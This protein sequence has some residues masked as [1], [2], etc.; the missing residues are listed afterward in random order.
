MSQPRDPLAERMTAVARELQSEVAPETLLDIAARL[1]VENVHGC[2]AAGISLV[3]RARV[4]E[5]PAYTDRAAHVSDQLQLE[6]DEGPGLDAIW[7]RQVVHSPDLAAE[8]RWPSWGPRT[9]AETGVRSLLSLRLFT[10]DDLVG[11]LN[12]YSFQA[13]AFDEAAVEDGLALAGHIAVAVTS[14][15]RIAQLNEALDS[16]TSIAAA[17][18]ILM[19]RFDLSYDRAFAVLGRISAQGNVKIRDLA[20]ELVATGSL[21]HEQETA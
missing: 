5:T 11:A 17:V 2:E 7:E 20:M 1:A 12:L 9:V 3:R 21:P 19:E 16:R 15:R 6:L 14:A 10:S 4:L 13:R 8:P 18:G